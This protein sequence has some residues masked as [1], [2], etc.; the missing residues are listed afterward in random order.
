MKPGD[1]VVYN[2]IRDFWC[3]ASVNNARN[4][5][6][7][8]HNYTLKEIKIAYHRTLIKLQETGNANFVADWFSKVI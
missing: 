1:K 8:G 7:V 3:I 6:V 2:G 4:Y 5:L